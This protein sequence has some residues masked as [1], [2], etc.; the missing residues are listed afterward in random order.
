MDIEAAKSLG[1]AIAIGFGAIGPGLGIGILGSGAMQAIG[2]N[3]EAGT[4]RSDVD[5]KAGNDFV[6]GC[7]RQSG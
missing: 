1:M 7:Q 5:G 4:V 2:R 6:D 3:P